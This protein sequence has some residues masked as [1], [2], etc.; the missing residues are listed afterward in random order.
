[1]I[2]M[3]GDFLQMCPSKFKS[4]IAIH[5]YCTGSLPVGHSVHMKEIY[6]NLTTL[7]H[8][9]LVVI[10]ESLSFSYKKEGLQDDHAFCVW[11]YWAR[12]QCY[13]GKDWPRREQSTPGSLNVKAH[14]L[15]EVNKFL[16]PLLH[17]KLGLMKN[18]MKGQEKDQGFQ[19][20][21]LK[22]PQITH[23]KFKEDLFIVLQI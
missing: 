22:F 6:V 9:F 8:S 12:D 1:M 11:D 13:I 23:V 7:R 17:I 19:Y 10:L 3:T 18:F 14:S 16:L 2:L 21:C 4:S 20:L 5:G 15:V